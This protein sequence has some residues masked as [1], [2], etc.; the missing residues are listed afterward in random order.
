MKQ[1]FLF[2]SAL[3]AFAS[4]MISASPA[5]AEDSKWQVDTSL[6]LFLAGMSGDVTAKGLP[7]SL[8]ASFSDVLEHLEAAAAG[9]VTVSRENWFV[10]AE[11]SYLN[12]TATVPA[13]S[14]D[15]EQWL[16]EPTVGYAFCDGFAA[17]VGARY[18]N[19][20][21]DVTFNGP[22]GRVATG[23]QDWWDPIVG[24]QFSLPLIGDKLSF[25]GRFDIGGFG[26][27]ADLT[28]QAHPF[29]NWHITESASLQL[30]YRWLATDY[31]TGSGLNKFRYDVIVEGLQVGLTLRF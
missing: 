9:R 7:A 20:H 8:D 13:A 24:A 29:L 17:F 5:Q 26:A 22:A 4:G 28:W 30:G 31:E 3:A 23:T 15:L 25:D 6:N 27:G 1:K 10:S 2:T 11:F 14:A 19:I 18:N 12:L 21:G 16:V